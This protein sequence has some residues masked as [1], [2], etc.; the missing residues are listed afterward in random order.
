MEQDEVD[1][2]VEFKSF[3]GCWIVV[4]RMLNEDADGDE[5]DD[6]LAYRALDAW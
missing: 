2:R 5:V 6:E 1:E 3:K 4:E